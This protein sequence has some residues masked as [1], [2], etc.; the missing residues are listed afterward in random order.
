MDRRDELKLGP[1]TRV[2][3]S[4]RDQDHEGR[5]SNRLRVETLV[6][7]TNLEEPYRHRPDGNASSRRASGKG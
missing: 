2:G 3:V 1:L 5:E 4:L 6:N 7:W